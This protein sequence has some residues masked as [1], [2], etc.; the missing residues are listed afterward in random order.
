[1]RHYWDIIIG[2]S[3]YLLALRSLAISLLCSLLLSTEGFSIQPPEVAL[4]GTSADDK[5]L[6][7]QLVRAYY[8]RCYKFYRLEQHDTV[9]TIADEGIELAVSAGLRFLE[10]QLLET[11]ALSLEFLDINRSIEVYLQ[12]IEAY[13][14]A[15]Y[16]N[17][18][19]EVKFEGVGNA[20]TILIRMY[21][22]KGNMTQAMHH[23]DL[24]EGIVEEHQYYTRKAMY[25]SM[26]NTQSSTGTRRK[27]RTHR[28]LLSAT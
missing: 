2:E 22:R 15:G 6:N 12:A 1:M 28:L 27:S 21:A 19:D 24:I 16:P 13:D 18:I 3:L 20:H 10:A 9:V 25:E 26:A 17:W 8:D 23:Y 11:K 5:Q 4:P 14:R 7:E